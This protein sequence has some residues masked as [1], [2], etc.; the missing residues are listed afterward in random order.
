MG[1][2]HQPH[3]ASDPAPSTKLERDLQ[4]SLY[5]DGFLYGLHEAMGAGYKGPTL[6]NDADWA[7]GYS[8]GSSVGLQALSG[9]RDFL[10]GK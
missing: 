4:L 3:P 2:H 7:C 8:H 6:H 5:R 9:Y 1:K 10:D